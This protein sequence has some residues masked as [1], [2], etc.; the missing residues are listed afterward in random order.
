MLQL[1]YFAP[2]IIVRN[3]MTTQVDIEPITNDRLNKLINRRER[4]LVYQTVF[5]SWL[6]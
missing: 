3:K 5:D 4:F 1:N 6:I 2:M